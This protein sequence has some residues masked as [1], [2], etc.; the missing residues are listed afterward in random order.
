MRLKSNLAADGALMLT[1]LIWGSTFFMAKDIVSVWPPMAYMFFRFGVAALLLAAMF[2]R[3]LA[4]ARGAE[5]RAGATLGVLM[6]FGFGLQA[7]GQ[8]Y[9]TASKSAF[10]TGLTTPLVPFVAY[11]LLRARP[12]V[13]N[14]LGVALASLGGLLILAPQGADGTVNFGDLLTLAATALFATHITLM[15]VYAKRYDVRQLTVLQITATAAL[16]TSVWVGLQAWESVAGALPQAFAREAAP[17]VWSGRVVWQLVYLAT[18]ATI[19]AFLIW[20]WGQARTSATHAAVIFSLEP[21]FATAFAVAVIGA[22]EWMGTRGFVGAAL[23]FAG[24]IISELRW[25]ERRERKANKKARAAEV[26]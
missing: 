3:Q 25:S 20:T 24:I 10:V 9:T 18:V 14:L 4:R 15:S 11:L 2:P 22:S 7:A 12:G 5:W 21:V 23:V 8:V 26:T 6:G 17:L 16:F 1:T 19:G 13:E